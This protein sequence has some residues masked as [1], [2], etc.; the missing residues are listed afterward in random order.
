MDKE[1]CQQ[2]PEVRWFHVRDVDLLLKFWATKSWQPHARHIKTVARELKRCM[3]PYLPSTYP[4]ASAWLGLATCSGL[5]FTVYCT[6]LLDIST[7][8]SAIQNSIFNPSIN[9]LSP[10]SYA[11]IFITVFT[12]FVSPMCF[13]LNVCMLPKFLCW[14]LI[15]SVMV[16]PD[17]IFGRWLDRE[18]GTHMN[19]I[20]ALIKETLESSLTP[21]SCEDTGKKWK[22]V[23]TWICWCH[24]LPASWMVG[25][26]FL[27]FIKPPF[28]G[29]LL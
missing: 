2:K 18:G 26:K 27:L 20:S 13:R 21:S 4:H 28:C 5:E 9:L 23:Q 3:V 10:V 24:G 11:S 25:N 16:F 19:G 12:A 14:P 29:I 8:C 1:R 22:R 15:P 7:F 17:G 6:Y